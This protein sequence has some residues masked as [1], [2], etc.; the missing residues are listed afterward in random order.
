MA[1]RRDPIKLARSKAVLFGKATLMAGALFVVELVHGFDGTTID[2]A[3]DKPW[4]VGSEG[5]QH[6]HAK[7]YRDKEVSIDGS[8]SGLALVDHLDHLVL[9]P[10]HNSHL[11]K[12]RSFLGRLH[13]HS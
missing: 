11:I 8:L 7:V 6:A 13:Q 12:R 2:Q 1:L 4:L 3:W 5:C 9:C 10:G